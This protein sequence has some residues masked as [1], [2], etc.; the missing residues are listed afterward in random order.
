MV[1]WQLS[2]ESRCHSGG[3]KGRVL[4]GKIRG[5]FSK[6]QLG[7]LYSFK[8][9]PKVLC[10]GDDAPHD[11]RQCWLPAPTSSG[12]FV[13]SSLALW[14]CPGPCHQHSET[15]LTVRAPLQHLPLRCPKSPL[16]SRREGRVDLSSAI[17]S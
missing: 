7:K 9:L 3:R 5:D 16:R 13:M 10:S 12:K 8:I 15:A 6:A 2:Q 4:V 17:V 1:S 11:H 14:H